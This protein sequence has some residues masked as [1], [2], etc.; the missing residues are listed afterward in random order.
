M[1]KLEIT[2]A[3][4]GAV[5]TAYRRLGQGP[6]LLLIHGAEADHRMFNGLI[7]ELLAHFTVTA[8]DQRDSGMT[9]NPAHDYDLWDLADD[10]AALLDALGLQSACV[11]GTSLGGTIAQALA[12]RHPA[13]VRKLVLGSTWQAGQVL[14][15]F[16]PHVATTLAYLRATPEQHA[17]EIGSYF[18]SQDYLQ[19]HPEQL[20]RFRSSS[21]TPTQRA[22][23]THM[24]STLPHVDPNTI[25]APT[26]LLAGGADR[27]IPPDVTF[28]LAAGLRLSTQ[29][30]I[31]NAPHVAP[32]EMPERVARE[33]RC[34]LLPN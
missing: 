13:R 31:E 17:A 24:Q 19:H 3:D 4:T 10:A 23:R 14:S 15:Q 5:R 2:H 1:S 26:L 30:L 12:S 9:W 20:D 7:A 8:Y 21:R 22:R 25:L 27:L 28:S 32:V 33:L 34:F 16:N 6:E 29:K 11:Y 18:F